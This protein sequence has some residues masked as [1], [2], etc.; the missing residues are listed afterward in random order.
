MLFWATRIWLHAHRQQ[1]HDDPIV[2]VALDP[3]TYVVAVAAGAIV[4]LAA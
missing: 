2:A 4:L 3:A 1:L